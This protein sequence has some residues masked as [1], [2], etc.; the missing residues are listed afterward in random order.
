MEITVLDAPYLLGNYRALEGKWSP[1]AVVAAAT[2]GKDINFYC[3]P[4][5]YL[6]TFSIENLGRFG[7]RGSLASKMC[8]KQTWPS[9]V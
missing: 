1:T 6:T 4:V 2:T 9:F 7:A 5:F 3:T 8:W